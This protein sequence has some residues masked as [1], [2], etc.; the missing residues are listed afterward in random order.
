[1]LTLVGIGGGGGSGEWGTALL[2]SLFA[3]AAHTKTEL[4]SRVLGVVFVVTLCAG[5]YASLLYEPPKTRDLRFD[6]EQASGRVLSED[7][8]DDIGRMWKTVPHDGFSVS[9][10]SAINAASRV[11]ATVELVGRTTNEVFAAVGHNK[12]SNDSGYNFPFW[13]V[14]KGTLVYRFLGLLGL[15]RKRREERSGRPE[16]TL[17]LRARLG[18]GDAKGKSDF[19]ADLRVERRAAALSRRQQFCRE[20]MSVL[21]VL[22]RV[23]R[24]ARLAPRGPRAGTFQCV[25]TIGSQESEG[26]GGRPAQAHFKLLLACLPISAVSGLRDLRA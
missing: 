3:V 12:T 1:M 14:E 25:A 16:A 17:H 18:R 19:A 21:A 23:E 7:L 11:F 24:R 26:S 15:R 5:Y 22:Q 10:V 2:L 6:E 20:M 4:A 9:P 13:P 8:A